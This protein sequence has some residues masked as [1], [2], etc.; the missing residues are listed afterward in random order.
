MDVN[1]GICPVCRTPL[2]VKNIDDR[3]DLQYCS[4]C[5]R[6]Y[7][8]IED[9]QKSKLEYDD[10]ETVSENG[11][12]ILLSDETDNRF[13]PKNYRKKKESYLTDYFG[14]HV[15]IETREFIPE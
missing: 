9:E 6:E 7:Y 1:L 15:E 8:P 11:E 4:S 3:Y 12:P 2:S 10:I 13:F 5:R 14:S